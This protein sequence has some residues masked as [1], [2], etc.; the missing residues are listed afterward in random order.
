M[1]KPSNKINLLS[2]LFAI[3]ILFVFMY[4]VLS[5]SFTQYKNDIAQL[6]ISYIQSQKKFISQETNRVLKYIQYKHQTNQDK[7][8]KQLQNEIVE[9]IENLRNKVDGTGYIFIYDFNGTNI[10]DP[11][12]PSNRGKNLYKIRDVTGVQ[13]IKELID[14]CKREVY[15]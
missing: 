11:I 5:N 14:T 2:L 8:I 1:N 10:S 13:V 4:I 7:P 9:T 12:Q 6:K 3:I 15:Y